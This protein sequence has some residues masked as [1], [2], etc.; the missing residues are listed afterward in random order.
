MR[1]TQTAAITGAIIAMMTVM[2]GVMH[3]GEPAASV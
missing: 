1:G 2:G 3:T